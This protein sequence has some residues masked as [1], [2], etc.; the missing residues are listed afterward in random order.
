MRRAALAAVLL[1][2]VACSTKHVSLSGKLKTLPTAEEN[3]RAGL[4]LAKKESWPEAQQFFEYV[5]TKFP[6]SKEA[7]L[8]DLRVADLKFSQHLW[9]EAVE[10]YA[11]FVQL[12]PSHEEVD[13]AEF[14]GAEAFFKDAPGEFFLFPPAHEKDQRQMERAATALAAFIDKYPSSRWVP[15]AK[16]RLGEANARLARR[17]WY[18]AEFYFKRKRWAGAASRYE[19]LVEKFPGSV[20][21]AEALMKLAHAAVA[22]DEKHRARTALQKLIV[23]HPQDPRRGEAEKLLAALR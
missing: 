7:A 16:K 9:A 3:Y 22:L 11:Q 6:F 5:K 12:H 20:N 18:V 1:V 21:E 13:Y 15:D 17:E 23:G 10:A 8:A 4:E 2:A 14:R 19:T